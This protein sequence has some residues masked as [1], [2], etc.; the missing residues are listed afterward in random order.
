M[1]A[2]DFPSSIHSEAN[3]PISN[4]EG[5]RSNFNISVAN[6]EVSKTEI[7]FFTTSRAYL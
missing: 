4:L 1:L 7:F 5:E 6:A 3:F 2:K